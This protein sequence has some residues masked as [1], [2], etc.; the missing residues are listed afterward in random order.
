MLGSFGKRGRLPQLGNKL[1]GWKYQTVKSDKIQK[2]TLLKVYLSP[3]V[4]L[5]IGRILIPFDKG[6][7]TS[8]NPK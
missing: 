3:V 2:K 5:S 1:L 7:K 8:E 4:K 6:I